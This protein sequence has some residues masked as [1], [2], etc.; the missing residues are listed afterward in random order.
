MRTCSAKRLDNTYSLGLGLDFSLM[1]EG[2]QERRDEGDLTEIIRSR[3]V[4]NC[5]IDKPRNAA[6]LDRLLLPA[7]VVSKLRAFD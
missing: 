5:P 3:A 1:H 2:S 7:G 6:E 4:C